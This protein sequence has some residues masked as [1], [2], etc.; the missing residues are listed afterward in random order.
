MSKSSETWLI[1]NMWCLGIVVA[2]PGLET[3]ICVVMA[4]EYWI[5]FRGAR[6]DEQK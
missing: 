5:V 2:P 6:D 3:V 4:V 1:F